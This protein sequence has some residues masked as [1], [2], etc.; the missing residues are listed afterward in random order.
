MVTPLPPKVVLLGGRHTKTLKPSYYK[1]K[2][3]KRKEKEKKRERSKKRK[4]DHSNTEEV[5][6]EVIQE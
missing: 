5:I 2:R 1:G 3:T 4:R 6:E